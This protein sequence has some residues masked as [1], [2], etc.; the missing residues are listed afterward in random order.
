MHRLDAGQVTEEE[1]DET[2]D[3]LITDVHEGRLPEDWPV[4]LGLTDDEATIVLH[5]GPWSEVAARRRSRG[6]AILGDV[7]SLLRAALDGRISVEELGSRACDLELDQGAAEPPAGSVGDVVMELVA[8]VASAWS[9]LLTPDDMA[10]LLEVLDDVED[11]PPAA[12]RSWTAYRSTIDMRARA[13][14]LVSDP[15]YGPGARHH[16]GLPEPR[17][18]DE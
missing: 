2:F 11:D 13:R 12:V 7:R 5:G 10:H 6:V 15:Y 3:R 14:S 18:T 9:T 1:A 8:Y 16:L 17:R 4:I